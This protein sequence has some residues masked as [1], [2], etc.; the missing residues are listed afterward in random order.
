MPFAWCPFQQIF[1]A[2]SSAIAIC[3]QRQRT[4]SF[5]REMVSRELVACL[6]DSECEIVIR[7]P[8]MP[9]YLWWARGSYQR[10]RTALRKAEVKAAWYSGT[11]LW[12]TLACSSTTEGHF[13]PREQCVAFIV[14]LEQQFRAKPQSKSTKDHVLKTFKHKQFDFDISVEQ[15][16]PHY[17]IDGGL[18]LERKIATDGEPACAM[19]MQKAIPL[20]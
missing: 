2:Y 15:K 13:P 19:P 17:I 5:L 7:N 8:S 18:R 9:W 10:R 11:K 12:K 1:H 4:S 20:C 6:D 3:D 14:D 16:S